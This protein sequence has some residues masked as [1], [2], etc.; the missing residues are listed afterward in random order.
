VVGNGD[1]DITTLLP[2]LAGYATGGDLYV[3]VVVPTPDL[4][5]TV[6]RVLSALTTDVETKQQR[7]LLRHLTLLIQT[8][9]VQMQDTVRDYLGGHIRERRLTVCATRA[10]FRCIAVEGERRRI[11]VQGSIPMQKDH[12]LAMMTVTVDAASCEDCVSVFRTMEH[13]HELK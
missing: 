3:A 12:A 10:A 7:P 4:L 8:P 1:W 2:I 6:D 5:S 13:L 11:V 9:T